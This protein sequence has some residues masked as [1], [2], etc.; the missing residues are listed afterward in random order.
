MYVCLLHTI[1]VLCIVTVMAIACGYNAH[2]LC[3][4]RFQTLNVVT[5]LG[6]QRRATGQEPRLTKK[7]TSVLG[8]TI[9]YQ[10]LKLVMLFK[11]LV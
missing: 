10:I 8:G 6:I 3:T 4:G 11:L 9:L 2:R 1:A 7:Q 5:M